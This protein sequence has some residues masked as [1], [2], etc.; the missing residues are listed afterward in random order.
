MRIMLIGQ[1][2]FG[3][4]VLESLLARGEDIVCVHSPPDRAAG[5]IDPLKALAVQKG[6]PLRQPST[7]R[8]EKIF[9][10]YRSFQPELTVMAFVTAIIPSKFFHVPEN[11]AICYHPSILPR[12]R[13]ASAINWA[14]IMGDTTTGLTIFHPDGGIDTGPII[15][16]KTIQIGPDDTTGNLYFNHLFPMGVDAILETVDMIKSGTAEAVPQ[17]E[18][19]AT[20]EPPCDDRVAGIDWS[21]PGP[22]LYNLVRGCDP[23]P[24][25]YAF[26]KGEK[27]R[28]YNASFHPEPSTVPPGTIT[29]INKNGITIALD[30]GTLTIGKVRSAK[31]GKL[32]A[33]E[34]AANS[35]LKAGEVFIRLQ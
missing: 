8:D 15:L 24:G 35:G 3:S 19:D 14:I 20:Y 27:I 18:E 13:G 9:D 10:D 17:S 23:Q 28:F 32:N 34:F 12:H 25:A 4:K 5:R 29:D 7:Y 31:A 11:G 22:H 33:V 1:G 26:L 6:L 30:G 21:I 2:P 16:Q